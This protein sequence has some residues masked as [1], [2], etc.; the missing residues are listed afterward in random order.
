MFVYANLGA[1]LIS[2]SLSVTAFYANT[3]TGSIIINIIII[4]T[5]TVFR[6]HC[7]NFVLCLFYIDRLRYY[8][9]KAYCK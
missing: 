9:Q 3:R 8:P 2:A 4:I 7:L 6:S 1:P 5:A